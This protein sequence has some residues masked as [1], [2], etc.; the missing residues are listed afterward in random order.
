M[1]SQIPP[2]SVRKQSG[3]MLAIELLSI[4]TEAVYG[5]NR[6]EGGLADERY[7]AS[8]MTPADDHYLSLSFS[9]YIYLALIHL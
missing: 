6:R 5:I 9:Q 1:Q 4:L 3:W 7:Q 8:G 2:R